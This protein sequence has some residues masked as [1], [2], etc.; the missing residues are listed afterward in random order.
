MIFNTQNSF[1]L[2]RNLGYGKITIRGRNQE[3]WSPERL[4]GQF[5]LED[6]N[7]SLGCL[8]YKLMSGQNPFYTSEE[9]GF[10][11]GNYKVIAPWVYERSPSFHGEVWETSSPEL[12]AFLRA[13]L[14]KCPDERLTSNQALNHEW[15]LKHRSKK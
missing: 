10:A 4:Y 14:L 11:H 6:D 7:F 15:V 2:F 1:C 9:E 12:I 5:G 3:Q 8:L 13:L